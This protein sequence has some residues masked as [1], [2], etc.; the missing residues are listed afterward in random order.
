MVKKGSDG[1]TI[2][3]LAIFAMMLGTWS[4]METQIPDWFFSCSVIVV[5]ISH[6]MLMIMPIPFVLFLRHMYHNGENKLW[7]FCCYINC[8]VIGVRVMLQVMG[9]YDLRETLVLTHIYLL[10][11]VAVIVVMTIH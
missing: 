9:V 3:Q 8:A 2:L 4:I 10:L 1:E 6:L 5:F 7:S 11:F